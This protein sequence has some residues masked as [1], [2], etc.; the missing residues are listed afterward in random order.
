M[1]AAAEDKK[2]VPPRA[3]MPP[4]A[5][6]AHVPAP[7]DAIPAALVNFDKP[8]SIPGMQ[9]TTRAKA[10]KEPNG[11]AW[12]VDFVPSMRHFRIVH[13]DPNRNIVKVGYVHETHASDWYPV[14]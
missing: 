3:V 4:P 10:G 9:S 14:E 12:Q 13:T 7:P 6:A 1:P 8:R 11:Q 2:P 5:V